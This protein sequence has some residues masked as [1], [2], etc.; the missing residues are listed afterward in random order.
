M[1]FVW[2]EPGTFI[3]GSPATEADREDNEGPQHEVTITTGFYLGTHEV[4]QEQWTAVMATT[5]WVGKGNVQPDHR[6][7]AVYFTWRTMQQFLDTL[8]VA[9]R[10]PIYRLPTEAEWEYAC[11]AG[12][13]TPWS[14][15]DDP[16]QMTGFSWY[17]DN[18]WFT[19]L[20]F[21]QPVG[22]WQ[23]NPWG[24][25]DMHGNVW[26]LT[27]DWFGSYSAETQSDPS[28]PEAGSARVIRG[29]G[30]LTFASGARSAYRGKFAI[31]SHGAHGARLVRMR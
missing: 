13:T 12:T 30:F 1:D 21:A 15:G 22:T 27:Q 28:G 2:I 6:H 31:P 20:A 29:G 18:A 17:Y 23:P 3:M 7:P 8:N 11:R 9:A 16:A 26:E 24:L 4:T 14:F 10:E 19:G 5:P 25:Y